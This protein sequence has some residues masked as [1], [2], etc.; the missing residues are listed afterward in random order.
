MLANTTTY[1]PSLLI[2]FVFGLGLRHGLD[3]DHLATIDSITRNLK[4]YHQLSKRVGLLFSL[5]H[6]LVV[7]TLSVIIS[8]GF[9]RSQFPTWLEPLGSFI[10][11]FFLLVFGLLTLHNLFRDGTKFHLPSS[12]QH[13]FISKL[14]RFNAFWIILTGA[15][16]AFSFD[17]FS[18]VAL[19]SISISSSNHWTFA[20]I[21][22]LIFMLGM[23]ATDGLNG[24]MVSLLIQRADKLSFFISQFLG[25]V[26][27]CFSL[28]LGLLGLYTELNKLS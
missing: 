27:A 17:T 13:F 28:L 15:L 10:S 2:F 9:I 16:F 25:V 12:V 26:I 11:I 6:G 21:L 3:L 18:Q 14:K 24:L 23:M 4:A 22:G 20:A 7:I 19:F 8:N 1:S 5:G